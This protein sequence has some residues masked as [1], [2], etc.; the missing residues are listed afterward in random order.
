VGAPEAR[1]DHLSGARRVDIEHRPAEGPGEPQAAGVRTFGGLSAAYKLCAKL[2]LA[3]A[4]DRA[5]GRPAPLR[6]ALLVGQL[7]TLAAMNRTCCPRSKRQ[8]ADWQKAHG[9]C[10]PS[11]GPRLGALLQALLGCGGQ[12]LRRGDR[13]GED[14]D[15]A[16]RHRALRDRAC[17]ADL[18]GHRLRDLHRLGR[19][20]G[21]DRLGVGR[22]REAAATC[23]LIGLFALRGRRGHPPALQPA[24]RRAI[25]TTPRTF[26]RQLG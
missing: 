9:A 19:R 16:L 12:A 6:Q 25:A 15:S 26:P 10:A 4:I 14:R 22:P 7:I 24:L 1:Q 13:Q 5:L 21:R 11:A 3:E 17:S 20:Q 8:L 18:R 2:G 23:G